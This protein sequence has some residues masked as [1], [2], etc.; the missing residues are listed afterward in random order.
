MITAKARNALLIPH[1]IKHVALAK[2]H[3][4]AR[5]ID[6]H[7]TICDMTNHNVET[8]RKKK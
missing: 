5:N 7:C 3:I 1:S 4:N 8:C 2:T 6:K